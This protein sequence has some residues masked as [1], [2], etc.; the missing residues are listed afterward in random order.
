M[1]T[2]VER[3]PAL[4][5][6]AAA[7][8]AQ[9]ATAAEVLDARD[10]ATFAYSSAKAAAR[11]AK[12]KNAHGEVLAACHK[13]QGDALVIEARAQCR[14][15]DEYDAAQDRGEVKGHGGSRSRAE[16]LK[17]TTADLGLTRKQVHQ[18]RELRNAEQRM[19][20]MVKQIVEEKLKA[21][22][23]PRRADVKRAISASAGPKGTP[24]PSK[25]A[26]ARKIIRSR[27]EADQPLKT[28]ELEKEHGISVDSFERAA[29]AERARK[30]ALDELHV[31]P[32]TLAMSA[33]QRLDAAVRQHIQ[34]LNVEFEQRVLA[35][36]RKRLEETILPSY[37]KSYAEYQ[38][39]VKARKGIMDRATY[40]T[41]LSCLHPD[42]V[43]DP[44]L[45][46]RFEDAFHLFTKMELV[47]LDEK[48]NPTSAMQFP[49]SYE[50]MMAL[51][52]KASASRKA[53]R[54]GVAIR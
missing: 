29:A 48:Q 37:N 53:R 21:G 52:Q 20:G 41:I 10:Q 42:R 30:E 49:R 3:L 24:K 39:V 16:R 1:A 12:S 4:I 2:D 34:K 35:E 9:A 32:E 8:L 51:K 15:A 19:P 50:E 28:R 27:V 7:S 46:K 54:Q 36:C 13:M 40:R 31:D 6:R 43:A 25:F 22:E 38:D 33:Q 5:E 47:L 14:L 18:A 17:P 26:E 23:E 44:G 45:K 11:F